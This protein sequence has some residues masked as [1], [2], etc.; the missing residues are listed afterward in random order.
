[1]FCKKDINKVVLIPVTLEPFIKTIIR[2]KIEFLLY[3][4]ISIRLVIAIAISIVLPLNAATL[5]QKDIYYFI[6]IGLMV[7]SA[8][9]HVFK[10]TEKLV[11][12][13][14]YHAMFYTS[15]VALLEYIRSHSSLHCLAHPFISIKPIEINISYTQVIRTFIVLIILRRSFLLSVTPDVSWINKVETK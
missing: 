15:S 2:D 9:F 3:V 13:Y 8:A 11:K 10:P 7:V 14:L 5:G 1:M 4:L 6:T 12:Y